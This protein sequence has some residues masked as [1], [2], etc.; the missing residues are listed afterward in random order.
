MTVSRRIGLGFALAVDSA[1]GSS[2]TDIGAIVDGLKE[3]E[4]KAETVDISILTDTHKPIAK[5]QSTS[6]DATLVVAYDPDDST[7]QLL[8]TLHDMTSA[9]QATPP[10]WR[11]TFPAGTGGAGS[12]TTKTFSAW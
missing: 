12:I 9:T 10:T 11:I 2:F 5:G 3:A 8:K 4:A 1:G 7:T 6:G